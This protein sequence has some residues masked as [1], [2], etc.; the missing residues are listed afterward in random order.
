MQ[1]LMR[2]LSNVI[3][4]EIEKMDAQD[5]STFMAFGDQLSPELTNEEVDAWLRWERSQREYDL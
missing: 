1:D 3:Y 5:Y 4:S 2:S